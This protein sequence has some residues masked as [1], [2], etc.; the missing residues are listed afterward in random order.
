LIN[1]IN[2]K[3]QTDEK[4]GDVDCYVFSSEL[5]KGTTRTL[6]IGKKDFLIHQ[7]KTVSDSEA[8]RTALDQA[9]KVNGENPQISPPAIT[10][11]TQIETHFNI[12]LNKQFSP[13]DF[14]R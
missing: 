11:I 2:E 12:V 1:S 14:E 5:R 8:V 6:W 4:I 7:V 9:S 13:P 3:Q 10:S